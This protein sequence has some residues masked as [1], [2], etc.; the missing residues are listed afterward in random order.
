MRGIIPFSRTLDTV[1]VMAKSP[2][3]IA[4][5]L[6]V[7][8]EKNTSGSMILNHASNLPKTWGEL[9]V[10]VLAP[11]L[12]KWDIFLAKPNKKVEQQLVITCS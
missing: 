4:N 2:V 10:G 9:K 8:M 11:E 3:D 6:D 5:V 1:G 12:W 7:I